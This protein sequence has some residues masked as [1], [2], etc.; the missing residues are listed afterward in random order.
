M[1]ETFDTNSPAS[2]GL[3]ARTTFS[4]MTAGS[5][6]MRACLTRARHFAATENTVLI[7]GE[8]GVGKELL[9]ESLHNG[10]SRRLKPFVAINCAALPLTL[11]ESELFGYEDGAFTGARRGGKPGYFE[12]A[13]GGTLFLDE[14]GLLPLHVQ[15][16]LLRVLESREVLRV[17][18][19]RMIPVDVRVLAAT[20]ADLE[21]AVAGGDFRQ[22]LYYRINVLHLDIP[23]LRKRPEDISLLIS[24]YLP[25]YAHESGRLITGMDEDLL[26]AFMRHSWPGNVRELLNYLRRLTVSG[27]GPILMESDLELCGIKFKGPGEG[28][29]APPVMAGEDYPALYDDDMLHLA[30][31]TLASLEREI[32]R[33]SMRRHKG[34]RR[35]VCE[36]LGVSRGTLWK[37]LKE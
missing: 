13:H 3:P 37:K 36:E 4:D 12:L 7:T 31:G 27:Q 32:I 26:A 22:D 34:N 23:P 16:Q 9:A 24:R 2:P 14:L 20:N 18:G 6:A 29:T 19:R 8:S 1:K 25:K 17:G 11:L 33:H 15:M 30:P 28:E 5:F 10:S 35:L 21:A